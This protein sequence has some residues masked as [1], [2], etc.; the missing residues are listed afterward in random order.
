MEAPDR[1]A[2]R[3]PW[4]VAAA[5]CALV[6]LLFL[7][8]ATVTP[9]TALSGGPDFDCG[10]ALTNVVHGRPPS[11]EGAHDGLLEQC[12]V[13]SRKR[14]LGYGSMGLT[15]AAASIAIVL[16]VIARRHRA[17]TLG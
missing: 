15:A 17:P 3:G 16:T 1:P 11:T 10:S 7:T 13:V 2:R 5:A 8:R 4:L 9:V 6:S 12:R 14:F